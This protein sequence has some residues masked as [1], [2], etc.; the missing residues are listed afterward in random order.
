MKVISFCLWG[1]KP[2]YN[3]GLIENIKLAKI[4]YPD[5]ECWLYIHKPTVPKQTIET[6]STF[7]NV[8]MFFKTEET[9]RPKRYMLWRFE[10]ADNGSVSHFISRDTD[11]RISPREVLAVQE[12]IESEKNLHIMRDHPQH[13]PKILGGMFGVRCPNINLAKNP[14]L[15]WS[16]EIDY[17]YK[18]RNEDEDDQ[19]FLYTFL[20]NTFINDCIIHDEIKKYEGSLCKQ[21]PIPFEQNGH[22]VGCYVDENNHI[23]PSTSNTLICYVLNFIPNRINNN[24]Q[25][26]ED[27]LKYISSIIKHIYIIGN[28]TTFSYT[29][30]DRFIPVSQYTNI[31]T[32]IGISLIVKENMIF[33]PDFIYTLKRKLELFNGDFLSF[34]NCYLKKNTCKVSVIIPTYNR[35]KYL[36]NAIESI[37]KQTYKNIELIIVNDGSKQNEYYSSEFMDILPEKS[38]LI[39]MKTNSSQILLGKEGRAAYSKN[40]GIKVATGE[41]IAFLDDDDYWLPDKLQKQLEAMEKTGGQM[42]ATDAYIGKGPYNVNT[43]YEKYHLEYKPHKQYLEYVL[44]IKNFP[45]VWT[46]SFLKKHNFCINSSVILHKNI[47]NKIGFIPYKSVGEDYS[48]WLNAIENTNCVYIDTPLIYYDSGHGD[49]QLY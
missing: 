35:Y 14:N 6:I 44:N 23:D 27:I 13:Y 32:E 17:F 33:N 22:F 43:I 34:E 20:Y 15:S 2:I 10:P 49:G 7:S 48:Y 28:N 4:Y 8:K 1:D 16:E 19:N 42:S 37:K 12:W 41:Y 36:L 9:I 47:V 31:E 18:C 3:I 29:L 40:A 46:P 45:E 39:N 11:S 24:Y 21:F 26:F 30:L 38:I 5:W 25:T